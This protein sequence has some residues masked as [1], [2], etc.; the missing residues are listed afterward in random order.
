MPKTELIKSACD[1]GKLWK[2]IEHGM[3][4]C[5]AKKQTLFKAAGFERST[6]DRRRSCPNEFKLKELE[7]IAKLFK[8]ELKITFE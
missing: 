7:G 3:I 5:D 6:Y 1:Y 8:K 4:D 2:D